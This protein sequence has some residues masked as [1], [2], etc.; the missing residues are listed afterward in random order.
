M[1]PPFFVLFLVLSFG[2]GHPRIIA[3]ENTKL[4]LELNQLAKACLRTSSRL[5][6]QRALAVAESLQAKAELKSNYACQTMALGLAADLIMS[7]LKAGRGQR[8]E[9]L[10]DEVN[11]LCQGIG[12]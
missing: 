4:L 9:Q 10:L 7:Q 3:D 5:T 6:C 12:I 11:K 8:A 1:K 2:F